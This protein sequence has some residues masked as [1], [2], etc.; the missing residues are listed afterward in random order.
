M[1]GGAYPGSQSEGIQST[2][3]G[4]AYTG[5]Q[6]E[7]TQS[8]VSGEAYP[9]SQFKEIQS[10]MGGGAYPGSQSERDSVYHSVEKAREQESGAAVHMAPTVRKQREVNARTQLAFSLLFSSGPQPMAW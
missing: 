9:G 2:V 4:E 1:R 8:I 5:T 6:S 10:T 3:R 7:G